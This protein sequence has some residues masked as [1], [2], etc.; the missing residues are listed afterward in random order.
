M[1]LH[2]LT[3]S[4]ILSENPGCIMFIL[5]NI[6]MLEID[7]IVIPTMTDFDRTLKVVKLSYHFKFFEMT[8]KR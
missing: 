2:V 8:F 1:F 6:I 5:S 7:K 3:C 4:A